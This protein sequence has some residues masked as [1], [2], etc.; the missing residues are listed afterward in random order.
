[1]LFRLSREA[2]GGGANH[3]QFLAYSLFARLVGWP[4]AGKI[5]QWID[6]VRP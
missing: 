4:A 5:S 6:R 2:S 1:M 3:P